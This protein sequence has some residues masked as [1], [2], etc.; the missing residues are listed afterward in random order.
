MA[1]PGQPSRLRIRLPIPLRF[2]GG[3]SWRTGET[4]PDGVRPARPDLNMIDG[5]RKAHALLADQGI[6]L[7]GRRFAAEAQAPAQSY[8]RK[9]CL[10]ALLAPDL[11]RSILE[12]RAPRNITLQGLLDRDPPPLLWSQQSA[13]LIGRSSVFATTP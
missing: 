13:W 2:R 9:L 8:Q 7:A 11:Q 10:L 3:R 1:E 5:L 4:G 6:D 12:G